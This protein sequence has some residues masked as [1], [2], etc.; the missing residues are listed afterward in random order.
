MPDLSKK[1]LSDAAFAIEALR[2]CIQAIPADVAASLPAMPGVDGDWLSEVQE[3][4][5]IASNGAT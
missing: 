1:L 5:R 3:N 4:L 2:E